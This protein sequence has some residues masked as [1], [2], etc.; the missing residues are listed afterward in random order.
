MIRAAVLAVLL[1]LAPVTI[2]V[3]IGGALV[4]PGVAP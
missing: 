2:T 4:H 3:P 1:T